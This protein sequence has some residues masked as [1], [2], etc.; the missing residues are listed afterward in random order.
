MLLAIALPLAFVWTRMV[1]AFVHIWS[2][3]MFI[4]HVTIALLLCRPPV[5]G[6]FAGGLIAFPWPRMRF[7]V[8]GQVTRPFE[9]LVALAAP[10]RLLRSSLLGLL[11]A[12]HRMQE[13]F[14][15]AIGPVPS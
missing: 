8:L 11:A 5:L 13:I 6:V 9:L 3:G 10:L 14:V 2:R 15:S 1:L 7:L 12:S 4:V